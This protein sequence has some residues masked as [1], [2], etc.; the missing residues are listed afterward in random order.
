MT[1]TT[2][3][4]DLNTKK[5]LLL[6]QAAFSKF[7]DEEAG[8]LAGILQEKHFPAGT[9]IVNEGDRVDSIYIIMDGMVDI[10]HIT[11]QPDFSH[12]ATSVATLG[13][14]T[15]IGLSETGFYSLTGKR[16]ATVVAITDIV[17]LRLSVA[18]FNGFALSYSR[19]TQVMRA[20]AS[21]ILSGRSVG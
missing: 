15:A 1:D 6:K 11:T 8:I 14:G 19:V 21:A 12:L 18:A 7:T 9:K 16:T 10:Q 4:I 17:A 5:A 3:T 20:H 13:P 2:D